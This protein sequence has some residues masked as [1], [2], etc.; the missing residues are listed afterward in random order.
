MIKN[1]LNIDKIKNIVIDGN[2]RDFINLIPKSKYSFN[3]KLKLFNKLRKELKLKPVA[4]LN[5]DNVNERVI[6]YTKDSSVV[7]VK[8][9]CKLGGGK[10][11]NQ[12]D[13]NAVNIKKI[14]D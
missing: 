12:G 14:K 1:L 7:S 4:L 3:K 10:I 2:L 5:D 9:E 6:S 8:D 13:I 11:C